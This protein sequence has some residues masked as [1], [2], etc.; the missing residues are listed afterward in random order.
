[1]MEVSLKFRPHNIVRGDA[2]VFDKSQPCRFHVFP[3]YAKDA[4]Q[5]S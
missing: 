2:F 5:V 1:M 4:A 3:R